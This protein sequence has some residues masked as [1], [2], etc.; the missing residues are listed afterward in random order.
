MW[1]VP[2]GH[3]HR[4]LCERGVSLK[5]QVSN[6]SELGLRFCAIAASVNSNCASIGAAKAA[7]GQA[8]E[9]A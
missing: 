7:N 5:R 6:A 9:Y 1:L 3:V 4:V 2:A 8:A